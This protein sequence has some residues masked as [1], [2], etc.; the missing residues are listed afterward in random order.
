MK[1]K[2]T[3]ELKV[4]GYYQEVGITPL[5]VLP[6]ENAEKWKQQKGNDAIA[7]CWKGKMHYRQIYYR[8]K[9][10][11]FKFFN[12]VIYLEEIMRAEGMKIHV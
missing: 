8:D 4:I 11:C 3:G 2:L 9:G 7:L 1:R 10:P 12:H 5:Y 6:F